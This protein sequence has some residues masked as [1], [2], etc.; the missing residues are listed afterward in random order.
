MAAWACAFFG[1]DNSLL[2]T[3][4]H[5]QN[6]PLTSASSTFKLS[7]SK[8]TYSSFLRPGSVFIGSQSSV[9]HQQ[10]QQQPLL[11]YHLRQGNRHNELRFA[12]DNNHP[13]P[14]RQLLSRLSFRTPPPNP[15]PQ[16][17]FQSEQVSQQLQLLIDRL[18][19][20]DTP[21]H[22]LDHQQLISNPPEWSVRVTITHSDHLTGKLSGM[23][24]ANGL[25]NTLKQLEHTTQDHHPLNVQNTT[26]NPAS[27]IITAWEG[28][29]IDLKKSPKQLWTNEDEEEA[30][31]KFGLSSLDPSCSRH[32]PN[33]FGLTS[34][35][36]DLRYWSKTKAFLGIHPDSIF[37]TLEDDPAFLD[38]LDSQFVLM[39]WKGQLA[40]SNNQAKYPLKFSSF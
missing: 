36:N 15:L 2:L 26:T 4:N 8:P 9:D 31:Y 5:R 6:S 38:A 7:H 40:L 39:R 27:M 30:R 12:A 19:H 29:T 33:T 13:F 22:C 34:H 11:Q 21:L 20:N 23:M 37:Q 35:L 25:F 1:E 32:H 28:Q 24:Q 14:A 3:I 18:H 17:H 16:S 10:Q